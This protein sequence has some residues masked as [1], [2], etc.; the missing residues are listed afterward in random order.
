M[1]AGGQSGVFGQSAQLVDEVGALGLIE[2]REDLVL[3]GLHLCRGGVQY[4]VCVIGEVH[5]VGAAVGRVRTAYDKSAF[6]QLV[7]QPDHRV[8]MDMQQIGELL[9]AASAG[10]RE[11]A[12]DPEMGR[13]DPDRRK[14]RGEPV[15]NM[16]A[17]LR[18]QEDSTVI[19]WL[20]R[21]TSRVAK[22]LDC[23]LR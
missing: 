22:Q 9:L 6:F 3:N 2:R 14:A 13:G 16:M 15:R 8:A 12:Q 19:Q 7:D 10:G 21:H 11:M 4:L 17:D 23:H 5:R 20:I 18:E 1:H